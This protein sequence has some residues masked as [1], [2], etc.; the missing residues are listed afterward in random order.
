MNGKMLNNLFQKKY[1][2]FSWKIRLILVVYIIGFGIGTTT[3]IID[4]INWGILPNDTAPDWKNIYWSSLTILDFIAII[5]ILKSI[6]PALI[7][8]NSIMISD[9]LINTNVLTYFNNYKIVLQIIFGFFVLITTPVIIHQ[10]IKNYKAT[11]LQHSSK[12]KL[13]LNT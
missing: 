5:L 7:L 2:D 8:A 11:C 3:H 4:I 12:E 13:I 9:V 10:M 6:A 1:H